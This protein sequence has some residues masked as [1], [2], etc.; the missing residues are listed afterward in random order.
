VAELVPE[1]EVGVE[2]ELKP[3]EPVELELELEPV[4]L[5]P[6]E[7]DPELPDEVDP[8]LVDEPELAE[9]DGVADEPEDVVAVCVEPG[10]TRAT[11]PA[12][13]TLD[14]V[15]AVVAERT[16]DRPCSLAATARRRASRCVLLMSPILRSRT[17]SP[18]HRTSRFAMR[19]RA[20]P[21]RTEASQAT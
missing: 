3:L 16:L 15:T 17:R 14:R 10:R 5:D 2:P 1:L 20:I 21:S 12:A 9:L 8:E 7:P 11:T 18:L 13:A 4:E 6:V 19:L